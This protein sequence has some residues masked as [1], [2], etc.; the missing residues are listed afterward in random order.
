M[1]WPVVTPFVCVFAAPLKL[2]SGSHSPRSQ[3]EQ[4]EARTYW[5][6]LHSDSCTTWTMRNC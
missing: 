3:P 4:V 2:K 1:L 5:S 6:L